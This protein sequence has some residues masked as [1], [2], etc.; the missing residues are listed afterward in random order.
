MRQALLWLQLAIA[1]GTAA[2]T[3]AL[4]ELFDRAHLYGSY[5]TADVRPSDV[6]CGNEVK[7]RFGPG[8]CTSKATDPNGARPAREYVEVRGWVLGEGEW[9]DEREEFV[10]NLALDLSWTPASPAAD[11]VH[12]INSAAALNA[13]I[14]P[15]NLIQ[16]GAG[17]VSPMHS[18]MLDDE[19]EVW[20]GPVS[21][22]AVLHV[23]IDGWGPVRR[24]GLAPPPGWVGHPETPGV[25]WPFDPKSPPGGRGG[26]LQLGDYVRIVGTLWED[27]PHDCR[28]CWNGPEGDLGEDAKAC[29]H[30]GSTNQGRWGRGYNEIHPVDF[31][32]RIDG[33][34]SA[35]TET[36]ELLAMCGTSSITRDIEPPGEPPT[37]QSTAGFEEIVDDEFTVWRSV[38]TQDRVTVLPDRI[39]V[40]VEVETGGFLGHGA[41][42]KAVYRVF[43]Q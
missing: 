8:N 16:F 34:T 39:R 1:S 11:H 36:V 12:P 29:W 17:D 43:W 35:T 40:H 28:T 10:F 32:A 5:G 3:P 14:T 9:A 7:P 27:E 20:G 22:A 38:K 23:E 13:A 15:H 4:L 31:L 30:G 21:R 6:F 41:K 25:F 42:F 2:C 26:P 24:A 33:P 18:A 37:P 19:G